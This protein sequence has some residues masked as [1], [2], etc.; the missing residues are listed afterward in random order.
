MTTDFRNPVLLISNQLWYQKNFKVL[1]KRRISISAAAGP[2]LPSF[3]LTRALT[4]KE[5]Q[6]KTVISQSSPALGPVL[7]FLATMRSATR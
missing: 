2:A 4:S 1:S 6:G 3:M 5:S 7:L